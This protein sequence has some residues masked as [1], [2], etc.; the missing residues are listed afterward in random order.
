MFGFSRGNEQ[1]ARANMKDIHPMT[2]RDGRRD[3]KD[4]GD[5]APQEKGTP[6]TPNYSRYIITP[7]MDRYNGRVLIKRLGQNMRV[8]GV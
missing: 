1:F 4:G 7:T 8:H 3:N 6:L 5:I 2:F